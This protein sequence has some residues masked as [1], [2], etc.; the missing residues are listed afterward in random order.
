M[1]RVENKAFTEQFDIIVSFLNISV[2]P[3]IRNSPRQIAGVVNTRVRL[4]CESDGLPKPI[5]TWEKNGEP[6]PTTGLRHMMLEKGSLEFVS[7]QI[8]D[9]GDYTC[10]ATNPAGN[11]TRDVQLRVQG[12]V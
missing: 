10:L 6:F 11:A 8:E 5:I 9:S 7:V 4:Q 1:Q 3:S 12:N 2:P